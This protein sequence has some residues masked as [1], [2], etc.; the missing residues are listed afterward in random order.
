M[1][2]RQQATERGKQGSES[3]KAATCSGIHA[4]R[5]AAA[6]GLVAGRRA[7][8]RHPVEAVGGRARILVGLGHEVQELD[9]EQARGLVGALDRRAELVEA[10]A[11]VAV[12]GAGGDAGMRVAAALDPVAQAG[13]LL[14]GHVRRA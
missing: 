1:T 4:A 7:Q 6:E 13:Q 14:L 5:V 11:L 9:V 3:R 8:Q 12:E 2:P 10:P